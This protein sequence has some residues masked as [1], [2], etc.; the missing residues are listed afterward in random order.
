[1]WRRSRRLSAVVARQRSEYEEQNEVLSSLRAC[2]GPATPMKTAC[3]SSGGGS[4]FTVS[5]EEKGWPEEITERTTPRNGALP[6]FSSLHEF[7][8]FGDGSDANAA[9]TDMSGFKRSKPLTSVKPPLAPATGINVASLIGG[10]GSKFKR[11]TSKSSENSQPSSSGP[12]FL[13]TMSDAALSSVSSL[14]RNFMKMR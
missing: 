2:S 8:C 12:T 6:Y 14:K 13:R 7:D 1:M 5:P 11:S 9:S 4:V 10:I 3:L